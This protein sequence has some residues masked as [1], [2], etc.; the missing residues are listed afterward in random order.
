MYCFFFILS[1]LSI[2]SQFLFYVFVIVFGAKFIMTVVRI[3]LF[4]K[5]DIVNYSALL[6]IELPLSGFFMSKSYGIEHTY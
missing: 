6:V 1:L 3:K 4:M 5:V 2:D